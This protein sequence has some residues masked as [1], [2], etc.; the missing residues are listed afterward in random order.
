M[1]VNYNSMTDEELK[2]YMLDHRD[3]EKAFYAYMDRRHAR[4][5][6]AL[7]TAEE[8]KLPFDEYGSLWDERM[9]EHFGDKLNLRNE[10][11]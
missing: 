8:A 10:Q 1:S 6:K 7:I 2:R 11:K 5:K 9:R 4:P 3:D